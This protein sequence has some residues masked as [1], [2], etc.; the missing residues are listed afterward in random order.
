M[1]TVGRGGGDLNLM[2]PK[3]RGL[4]RALYYAVTSRLLTSSSA[5]L[6]IT[7]VS[8]LTLA[9]GYHS[10]RTHLHSSGQGHLFREA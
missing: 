10:N 4:P 1:L 5:H 2:A 8:R 6:L 3:F 7:H 9:G